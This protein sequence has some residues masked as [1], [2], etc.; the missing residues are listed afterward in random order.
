M[1]DYNI[2]VNHK[3]LKD[4]ISL[5]DS[6]NNGKIGNP[7]YPNNYHLNK[8]RIKIA[9]IIAARGFNKKSV[10]GVAPFF[11]QRLLVAIKIKKRFGSE[12]KI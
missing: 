4:N 8:H 11:L 2:D 6:F 3:D 10:R 1:V 5:N 9:G 12:E 7:K